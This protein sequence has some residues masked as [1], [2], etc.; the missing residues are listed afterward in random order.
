MDDAS[1]RPEGSAKMGFRYTMQR[2]LQLGFC[3]QSS[4]ASFVGTECYNCVSVGSVAG[5]LPRMVSPFRGVPV[6]GAL[7][8]GIDFFV[9]SLLLNQARHREHPVQ[10]VL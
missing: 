3:L 7:T 2:N 4:M 9:C 1:K 8:R 5:S 6:R 10:A